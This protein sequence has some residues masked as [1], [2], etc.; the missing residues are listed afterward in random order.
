MLLTLDQRHFN[1]HH[2]GLTHL[3]ILPL[4][5]LPLSPL[6]DL[7]YT[8]LSPHL[9]KQSLTQIP[10]QPLISAIIIDR[11]ITIRERHH[12]HLRRRHPFR[13]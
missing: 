4:Y 13:Y 6:M 10:I 9:I 11:V 12:L 5:N 3:L 1:S 2:K 7:P 8:F